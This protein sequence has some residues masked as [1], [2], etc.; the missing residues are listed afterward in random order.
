MKKERKKG[1][2]KLALN[3]FLREKNDDCSV[4]FFLREK[5]GDCSVKFRRHQDSGH[6]SSVCRP[7]GFAAQDQSSKCRFPRSALQLHRTTF[8]E[9]RK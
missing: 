2:H 4:N 3:F 8:V 7:N 9:L 5:N 1:E 6:D